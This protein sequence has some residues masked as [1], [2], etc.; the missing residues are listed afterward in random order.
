MKIIELLQV[1]KS[2]GKH[3][4]L[5]KVSY[6]F[7]S[8]KCYLLV[9]ENGSGKSTLLKGLLGLINLDSGAIKIPKTVIGYVP[10][11][12]IFPEFLSVDQCL[13]ELARIRGLEGKK[14]NENIAAL[15][16]EWDLSDH[17]NRKMGELSKGMHQ[18]VLII[19]ALLAAPELYFFDEPMSGL[20]EKSQRQLIDQMETLKRQKKTLIVTTHYPKQYEHVADIALMMEDGRL[21][22]KFD[23]L[24][25]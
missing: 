6:V 21:N 16:K 25:F 8:G 5:A 18:K 2:Y 14:A 13:S 9:G 4:V 19:Q 11:R 7:W 20:D 22:E 3:K 23:F 1:T 17:G 10:E 15:L 24:P 12:M